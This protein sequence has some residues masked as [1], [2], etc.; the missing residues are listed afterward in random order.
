VET[1]V[2]I[3]LN[4][5]A[6]GAFALVGLHFGYSSLTIAVGDQL[7]LLE[8]RW[9]GIEMPDGRTFALAHEVGVQAQILGPWCIALSPHSTRASNTSCSKIPENN[10]RAVRAIIGNPI[11]SGFLMAC[12]VECDL[13]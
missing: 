10:V 13:F 4:H 6:L 5:P 12:S 3:L 1:I 9:L 2:S 7:V 8:R 11:P